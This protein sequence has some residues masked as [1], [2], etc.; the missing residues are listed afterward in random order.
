MKRWILL[1]LLCL[2]ASPSRAAN[3]TCVLP[4]DY[5]TRG[6][7]LCEEL[8]LRLRIRSSEWS[9]DACASQFLRIGMLVSDKASTQKESN[10]T[11]RNNVNIAVDNF[12]DDWPVLVAAA[13]G[14][15]ILDTEFGEECDDG[16]QI[17]GDGCDESC[18]IEP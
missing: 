4:A 2:T 10:A 6:I 17:D 16:N 9:N 15:N 8:R 13:C 18:I 3:L 11:V 14:D 7:E 12:N 5:V 1:A